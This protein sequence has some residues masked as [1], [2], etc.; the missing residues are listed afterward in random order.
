[1]LRRDLDKSTQ[2]GLIPEHVD[3]LSRFMQFSVFDVKNGKAWAAQC[4]KIEHRCESIARW[5]DALVTQTQG[6]FH[7]KGSI[8][9][10][11]SHE[12]FKQPTAAANSV[13]R[14]HTPSAHSGIAWFLLHSLIPPPVAEC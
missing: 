11:Q 4:F 5:Q 1:V 7:G 3:R 6:L 13:D 8:T 10:V 14:T 2:A 12:S 9:F